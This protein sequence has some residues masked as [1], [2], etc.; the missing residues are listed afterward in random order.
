M[1]KT[2]KRP[3]SESTFFERQMKTLAT[4][5]DIKSKLNKMVRAADT[6]HKLDNIASALYKCN[7][8]ETAVFN[9]GNIQSGTEIISDAEQNAAAIYGLYFATTG[10]TTAE[11]L[12][13]YKNQTNGKNIIPKVYDEKG[14]LIYPDGIQPPP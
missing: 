13:E 8:I 11:R 4:I 7:L 12:Q 14:N 9:D 10:E 2:K 1:P 5:D 6:P 3:P